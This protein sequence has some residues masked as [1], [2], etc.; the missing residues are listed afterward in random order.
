VCALPSDPQPLDVLGGLERLAEQSLIRIEPDEHGDVRL[1]MLET[2]RE[3]A[4]D[5]LAAAGELEILRARHAETVLGLVRSAAG[6]APGS[7]DR[8]SWLD[9]LE[10]GH[11]NVRAA[12]AWYID[13]GD[14]EHASALLLAVWRFWQMRS[15]LAEGRARAAAVL[16]MPGWDG[17][18]PAVRAQA[19]EAAGGLAYWAGDL[20]ATY[21]HYSAAVDA[22]RAGGDEGQLANALYNNFFATRP[23]GGM[24]NWLVSLSEE[25]KP[26]LDEALEIWTRLGDEDGVAK[27]LWGL[28][29]HR[30]YRGEYAAAED[31]SS[32]ALA[33]FERSGDRFW[34]AWTRFTRGFGR[35]ASGDL[36]GACADMGVALRDFKAARDVSG[37]ALLLSAIASILVLH[38]R[39]VEGHAM[40]G[41]ANLAIAQ[42]GVHLAA[43]WPGT[44]FPEPEVAPTD[45]VLAAAVAEGAAWSRDEAVDRALAFADAIAAGSLEPER[46]A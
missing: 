2:I 23:G 29:E 12:L 33:H 3:Y 27:A 44:V 1:G 16:N 22:A 42:T 40:G 30:A 36:P 7:G 21:R 15:H 8:G 46:R 6:D 38:G 19:L 37:T 34:I 9:R 31:A 13:T 26:L 17:V 39:L 14:H 4:R 18:S 45:P 20:D 24:E 5:R 35:A 28:A 25:G 11:D 41:A 10:D 32:R 43:L